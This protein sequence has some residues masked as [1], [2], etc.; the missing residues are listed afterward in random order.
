MNLFIYTLAIYLNKVITSRH[1]VSLFIHLYLFLKET[2]FVFYQML[3]MPLIDDDTFAIYFP[4]VSDGWKYSSVSAVG[5]AAS[6]NC[7]TSIPDPNQC[8]QNARC[9]SAGCT[10]TDAYHA[11]QGACHPRK[12]MLY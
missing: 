2:A 12:C 4:S 1:I 11:S 5:I 7:T 10:C 6:S 8:V 9:T 3:L